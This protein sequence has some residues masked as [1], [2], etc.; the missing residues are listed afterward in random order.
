MREAGR[1]AQFWVAE[2]E[3]GR[4]RGR[5]RQRGRQRGD[6]HAH[7]QKHTDI[8]EYTPTNINAITYTYKHER[9]PAYTSIQIHAQ[10]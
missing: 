1:E 4:Q 8:H 6:T 7:G 2:R 3:R 9:K 10:T 5:E